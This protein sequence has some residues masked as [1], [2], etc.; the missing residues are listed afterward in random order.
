MVHL[1][2]DIADPITTIGVANLKI[3]LMKSNMEQCVQS[4]KQML[5]DIELTHNEIFRKDGTRDD[6][7][8]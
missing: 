5:D 4:V 8:N 7:Y 6:F 3:K 1:M 2:L